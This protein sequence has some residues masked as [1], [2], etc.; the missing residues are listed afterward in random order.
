MDIKS[1]LIYSTENSLEN[2]IR[3]SLK[4]NY[5]NEKPSKKSLNS[6]LSFA[7]SYDCIETKIGRLDIMFN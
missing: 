1:T 7:A 3:K 5:Q 2:Q 4:E 6:I